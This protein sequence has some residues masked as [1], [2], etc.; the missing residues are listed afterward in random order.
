MIRVASPSIASEGPIKRVLLWALL[1]A[2]PA[3]CD[4]VFSTESGDGEDKPMGDAS[5]LVLDAIRGRQD[6]A[7][8]F[9]TP[10]LQNEGGPGEFYIHVE[11]V[12]EAISGPRTQCG[13]T[14]T[15]EVPGGWRD[16]LDFVFECPRGPQYLTVYTR[17]EGASEFRVTDE[18]VY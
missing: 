2:I 17:N 16:T 12:P 18:W 8:W 9:I 1:L 15:I 7:A 14:Q 13:L 5:V 11:G 4:G 10:D 3:A 6:T